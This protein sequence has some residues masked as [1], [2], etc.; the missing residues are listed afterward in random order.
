[1]SDRASVFRRERL[2][3]L[4]RAIT[5]LF[6]TVETTMGISRKGARFFRFSR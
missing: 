6:S 5:G 3:Q 2:D 1:M 4:M